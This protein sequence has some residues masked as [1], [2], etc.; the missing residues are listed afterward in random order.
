[1]SR[2]NVETLR[3]MA[4]V[5]GDML[6]CPDCDSDAEMVEHVPGVWLLEVAHESTCPLWRSGA[7]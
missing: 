7:A 4:R 2:P 6:H 3:E 5:F 1:M